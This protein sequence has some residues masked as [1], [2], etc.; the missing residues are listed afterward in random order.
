MPSKPKTSRRVLSFERLAIIN[1]LRQVGQSY[2]EIADQ[3]NLSRATVASIFQRAS[4]LANA[5]PVIKKRIGRP[6]KLNNRESRALIRHIDKNPYDNL[7]A[8]ATP[9][10]SGQQLSTN[11]VRKYMRGCGFFRYKARKKPYLTIK[12]KAY[13]LVWAR[14]HKDWTVKD[15]GRVVWTDE[16]TFETG[17]DT[18][19]CFV[20]RRKGTAFEARYLKPTFKSG[21]STI[22]IWGGI[23]LKKKGPMLILTK[24]R[25]MNSEIYINEVLEPI[26]LPFFKKCY[27]EDSG[28]IWM[29]D[30]AAYH[31]SK[32]VLG[33]GESNG[34]NRMDW[35]AQS[36]DL[37]PIENLWRI[38]KIRVSARRHQI[39]T[40]EAME[41]AIREEWGLLKAKDYKRCIESMPKRIRLII[42]AK[43]GAIKY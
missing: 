5:S 7:L 4:K 22:G 11:T 28:M 39:H 40:I 19:S 20:S 12:H 35:P 27:A 26:G 42:Q 10:K 9:S 30:G 43:G 13:R 3:L 2:G 8:L 33:W 17:L 1:H 36:P 21:R 25:R 16:A 23:T 6:P 18:R 38:I 31:T 37:N 14:R 34:L 32:K 24:G 29:D 15:W 41:Q